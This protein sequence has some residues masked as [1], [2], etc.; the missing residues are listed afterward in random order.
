MSGCENVVLPPVYQK[1]TFLI[2]RR[3]R[4]RVAKSKCKVLEEKK[5]LQAQY[6]SARNSVTS[7]SRKEAKLETLKDIKEANSNSQK[8]KSAKRAV[9]EPTQETVQLKE[10]ISKC[11]S[12]S[13][14]LL[15]N[16]A[17]PNATLSPEMQKLK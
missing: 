15:G 8:W 12:C 9:S 17:A 1:D 2:K 16:S 10:S 14:Q 3:N 4:L 11:Q 6:N 13:S 5:I 7:R